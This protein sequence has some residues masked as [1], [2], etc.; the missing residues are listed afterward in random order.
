MAPQT[1]CLAVVL[2]AMVA[3]VLSEE[4]I[5][6]HLRKRNAQDR[7][8]FDDDYDL[9]S[10]F[11]DYD[12]PE[13]AHSFEDEYEGGEEML[14]DNTNML[15]RVIRSIFGGRNNKRRPRRRPRQRRPIIVPSQQLSG[16]RPSARPNPY[17]F[18][19]FGNRYPSALP[20]ARRP[21]VIQVVDDADDHHSSYF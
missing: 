8:F 2:M 10:E 17:Q 5:D 3:T 20:A 6:R 9:A 18:Q 15:G 7:T 11:A 13:L 12:D 16:F 14:T 21:L 1:L 4:Q 19:G